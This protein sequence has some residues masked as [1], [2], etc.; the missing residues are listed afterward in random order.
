MWLGGTF[1]K[2]KSLLLVAGRSVSSFWQN[3]GDV[4]VNNADSSTKTTRSRREGFSVVGIG[5]CN[6]GSSFPLKISF[7]EYITTQLY[8][9]HSPKRRFMQ[10]CTKRLIQPFSKH[11]NSELAISRTRCYGFPVNQRLSNFDSNDSR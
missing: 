2:L 4:K 6:L 3:A 7:Q 11:F 5:E 1:E 10:L 8:R 9:H